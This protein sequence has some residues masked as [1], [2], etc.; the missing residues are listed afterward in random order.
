MN[1]S[2]PHIDGSECSRT[3]IHCKHSAQTLPLV[4]RLMWLA[5]EACKHSK[6]LPTRGGHPFFQ[7]VNG[8]YLTVQRCEE[9]R[10]PP[11]FLRAAQK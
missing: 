9:L 3:L 1:S 11:P 10:E 7:A 4:L 6:R 8:G 5:T 2:E